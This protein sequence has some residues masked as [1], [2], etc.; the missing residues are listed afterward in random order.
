LVG[1][2]G[3]LTAG[4]SAVTLMPL[5][6]TLLSGL[7]LYGATRR[8]RLADWRPA[9]YTVAGF[10]IGVMGLSAMVPGPAGRWRVLVLALLL[11]VIA[12]TLALR[13]AQA[14]APEFL[15]RAVN[16]IPPYV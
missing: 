5:G 13:R 7:L 1:H 15:R 2:G 16:A 9:C 4:E 6:Q 12:T 14:E 8:A 11:A 10:V 3:T